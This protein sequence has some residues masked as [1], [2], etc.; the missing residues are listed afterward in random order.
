MAVADRASSISGESGAAS[1]AARASG[2][3][4]TTSSGSIA[5]HGTWTTGAGA[6]PRA[7][8]APATVP[9]ASAISAAA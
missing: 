4:V 8:R 6:G 2:S 1:G 9:L 5:C 7:A 3:R